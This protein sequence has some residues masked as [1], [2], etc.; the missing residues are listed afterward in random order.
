MDNGFG[1][2]GQE[3]SKSNSQVTDEGDLNKGDRNRGTGSDVSHIP[4]A[5]PEGLL[6]D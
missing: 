3:T 4:M 2:G 5:G 1:K 6:L